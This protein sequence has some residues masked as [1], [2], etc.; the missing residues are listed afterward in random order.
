MVE[1]YSAAINPPNE[2]KDPVNIFKQGLESVVGKYAS[3]YT[4]PVII[5][6]AAMCDENK[7]KL[8]ESKVESICRNQLPFTINLS[9]FDVF[10]TN[11]T[12]FIPTDETSKESLSAFRKKISLEIKNA[13]YDEDVDFNIGK[14]PHITI[15]RSLSEDQYKVARKYFMNRKFSA[16][17]ECNNLS[18]RKLIK[19]DRYSKYEEL[20]TFPF[21]M[22]N[23]S[24]F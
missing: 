22:K 21:A 2:I 5:L 12:V 7:I 18:W 6:F 10:H 14:T 16:G 1:V 8:I 19:T 24:L 15:A 11:R 17:F 23:L 4:E 9:G 3:F 13:K 20:K